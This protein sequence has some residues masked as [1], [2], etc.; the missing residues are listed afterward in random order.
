MRS[1]IY[2]LATLGGLLVS[3]VPAFAHGQNHGTGGGW[4]CTA[5][6]PK[7]C[8]YLGANPYV[9]PIPDYDVKIYLGGN[10][11]GYQDF[12]W[13]QGTPAKAPPTLHHRK[14]RYDW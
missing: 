12:H 5:H 7:S 14:H 10:G 4:A 6:Y 3:T 13:Q 2:A 9:A 8:V 1:T 11:T